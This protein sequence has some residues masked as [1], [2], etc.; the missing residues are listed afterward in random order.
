MNREYW[1]GKT[2]GKLSE[3]EIF[4][5]GTNPE[6]RH[7][8]GAAKAGMTFGAIYGQ[9]R[10][11]MGSTYGLITKNLSAGFVE[12][13]TGILYDK[14]GYRSVSIKQIRDNIK[15]L[16]ECARIN[17]EKRFLIS[18]QYETWPN[19]IPK[20]SLNGYTSKEILDMFIRYNDIP[21][22]IIFHDSYTFYI[23]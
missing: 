9:G 2:I 15:E 8:A 20:K 12:S 21:N 10:G 18:Y 4:V 22:N 23:E 1:S 5:M 19:G 11:L 16:Y 14:A 13:S 6:G 3:N 7:G 17:S